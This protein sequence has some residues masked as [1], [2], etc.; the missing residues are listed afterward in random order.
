LLLALS[1]VTTA[2]VVSIFSHA[3]ALEEPTVV[4]NVS[5]SWQTNGTVQALAYADGV[6]YL[7][8]QFT[9]VRPPDAPAG[10]GEVPRSHLA[11]LDAATGALL[12]SS[13][14]LDG[15]PTTLAASADGTRLYVGG[16]FLTIDRKRRGHLA[17]FDTGTGALTSWAPRI[18]GDVRGLAVSA[19]T[20]YIAG[21]FT[22]LTA[23][24]RDNLEDAT[25]LARKAPSAKQGSPRA[26]LAAVTAD[27]GSLLPWAP[28][29]DATVQRVA[30]APDGTR[31]FVGGSFSMLN[32]EPRRG[33]GSLD[34]QTGTNEPW[35]SADVLPPHD[36]GCTSDVTD[37]KVDAANVYFAAEGSP[38]GCFDGTFAATQNDGTL[39]WKNDCQGASH[40]IEVVSGFLY[41][42]SQATDCSS[43]GSFPD[44]SLV[45]SGPRHLLAERASDG[46]I[47]PWWPNTG[48]DLGPLAMTTDG[49]QLFVGGDFATVNAQPQQGFTRFEA[50]GPDL[51]MPRQPTI[52]K[53]S[54]VTPGQVRLIWQAT[55][56]NDD[57]HLIY[58]VYRDGS[59]TPI[60]TTPAVRSTFWIKPTLSFTD[61]GLDP[62]STHTYTVDAVE[63]NGANTS[64]A[65]AEAS[66]TV[67]TVNA[68][69][70][71]T[72]KADAPILYWR[73]GESSGTTAADASGNGRTGSYQ[74][75]VE[76]GQPG[77]INGDSDTAVR[78]E[79]TP[80]NNE[81]V[82]SASS[83]FGQQEF[84]VELWF[85]T[86]TTS[87]GKLI[88][89]GDS[90]TGTSTLASKHIYMLA[91]GRLAFGMLTAT[92]IKLTL[93]TLDRY[94]NGAYHH[95]TATSGDNGVALYVDGRLIINRP[96]T[97][98]REFNGYWRV[99]GDS[100][101]GWQSRPPS[102][103]FNGTVDEVAV[104]DRALTRDQVS[105][106]FSHAGP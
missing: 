102:D 55:T 35:A 53:A 9:S 45:G 39:V 60:F 24:H 52:L 82:T 1:L 63:A 88:G 47:G 68:P 91:D 74:G 70:T 80:G 26:N 36:S 38:D 101:T 10:T 27:S 20:V 78:L 83:V 81:F 28:T 87:G 61:T 18:D 65:S 106:H 72:V 100:L 48:G 59:S 44:V 104:Y 75:T 33:T 15:A 64:P 98:A 16:D 43:A 23:G 19:N 99:G 32:G 62:G 13:H 92:G 50:A 25:A 21:T 57:E 30:V 34:P 2:G 58:R 37:V 6:V 86:T 93:T 40:A 11:A 41:K 66:V 46:S 56:D 90:Q 7:G 77:A 76:L 31:V 54:S 29:A 95:V 94:N 3:G 4:A 89:F 97:R 22:R 17:A 71:D 5:P 51:S 85:S 96:P 12:P 73:L 14:V 42:G 103:Y 84:S 105:E 79:T 69:Y 49:T 8:G 67:T